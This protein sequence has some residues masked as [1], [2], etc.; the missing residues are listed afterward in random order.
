MVFRNAEGTC[1]SLRCRKLYG[2][3]RRTMAL[4]MAAYRLQSLSV[5]CA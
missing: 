2:D 5:A 1:F 3:A 4:H